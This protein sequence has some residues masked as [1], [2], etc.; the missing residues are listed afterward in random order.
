M[1]KSELRPITAEDRA[2]IVAHG[3]QKKQAHLH[4][5]TIQNP[6]AGFEAHAVCERCGFSLLKSRVR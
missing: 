1:T 3:R 5:F 2:R 4:A 6:Q